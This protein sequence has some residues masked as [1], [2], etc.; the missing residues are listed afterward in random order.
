MK[1]IFLLLIICLHIFQR[2]QAAVSTA[3][4]TEKGSAISGAILTVEDDKY[5]YMLMHAGTWPQEFSNKSVTDF[6]T[7]KYT[8]ENKKVYS[9]PWT[10]TVPFTL[11]SWNQA[12]AALPDVTGSLT[13]GYDPR[14]KAAYKDIDVFSIPN[15]YKTKLIVGAVTPTAPLTAI[16]TDVIIESSIQTE[17]YY[18]LNQNSTVVIES[19]KDAY[20]NTLELKWPFLTGAEEYDVEWVFVSD[21]RLAKQPVTDL[22]LEF[23]NAT[24]IS[25]SKNAYKINLV[26]DDGYIYY[27]VR[28]VGRKGANFTM[29]QEGKWSTPGN[30]H[31]T[32]Y[33]H[34]RNWSYSA[35]YAEDGKA[36]EVVSFF[37]GSGRNRQAVTKLN[38]ENTVLAT[39]IMYDFEGR[40]GIQTLPAPI[41]DFKDANGIA[42]DHRVSRL[43]FYKQYSLSNTT[44]VEFSS[45]DFDNDNFFSSNNCKPTSNAGM[46]TAQGA[47]NYYSASNPEKDKGFNAVIP[48]AK[49]YP[50][51]QTVYDKE[52][53]VKMQSG[54]GDAHKIGAGH[55]T[56]FFNATV[57][58]PQ[59]DRLFGND[60]GYAS[61]YSQKAVMDANG[62][63]S[64]SYLDLSGK[65]IASFLTGAN[66][67]NL[68]DLSGVG[69]G[70][71]TDNFNSLNEL[72]S[73]EEALI[74]DAKYFV[75]SLGAYQFN[76]HISKEQYDFLCTDGGTC[77]YDLLI[78][79]YDECDQPVLD[80]NNTVLHHKFVINGETDIPFTVTF[81]RIGIYKIR[82]KLS[83]NE[84]A[85]KQALQLF[86]SNLK[87]P[88]NTCVTSLETL[89]SQ[90]NN[91]IDVS[92]CNVSAC[93]QSCKDAATLLYGS[94][95]TPEWYYEVER[96]K[97]KC[98][99]GPKT[100]CD[101]L[102][103]QL[104]RDMSPGG[105]YFE[106][107]HTEDPQYWFQWLEGN[108]WANG[109][110]A[111]WNAANFLD[112]EQHVITT[113]QE[114][115]DNWQEDYALKPF[116][117]PVAGR[118]SLVEFHP[119]YCH[120]QWCVGVKPST[121]FDMTLAATN[122]YTQATSTSA[123]LPYLDLNQA[124]F[125][126]RNMVDTDPYFNLVGLGMD[127]KSTMIGYLF[128]MDGA[129]PQESMWKEALKITNCTACT[130]P[131]SDEQWETF[132]ALYLAKKA[133]LVY[134]H[135]AAAG[136][137]IICDSSN[138]PDNIADGCGGSTTT[139][140]TS[141]VHYEI[142]VP[143][144]NLEALDPAVFA[145]YID[146]AYVPDCTP[147]DPCISE[148]HCL[149]EQFLNYE[150]L[151][152]YISPITNEPYVPRDVNGHQIIS[153]EAF[154]A[155]ALNKEYNFKPISPQNPG[156]LTPEYILE[157]MDSCRA[158]NNVNPYPAEITGFVPLGISND[159][160]KIFRCDQIPPECKEPS[161]VITNFY[162]NEEYNKQVK[163]SLE[164]F[165]ANYKAACLHTGLEDFTVVH[166]EQAG[167]YTLYYYDRAGN[168]EKTVP[169]AGVKPLLSEDTKHVGEYRNGVTGIDPVYPPH[170]LVTTYN[171]NTFNE[172]TAQTTPD[173]GTSHFWYN[174]VG[175]LR[176]SM[177]AKQAAQAVPN[178]T[179]GPYSYT[180]YDAQGR[181][182]EVGESKQNPP[183]IDLGQG[184]FFYFEWAVN[185][186][187]FPINQRKQVTQTTYDAPYSQLIS[188]LFPDHK[189]KNLRSRVASVFYDEDAEDN[190]APAYNHATHYSYDPHGNVNVLL[191]DNPELKDIDQNIKKIEYSYDLVSGNVNQVSYQRDAADQFHHR[192][193]YDDDNR[194]TAAFTSKDGLI[195]TN[196]AKYYYY[197]HGPLARM[198]LGDKKVQGLDYAYTIQGWLKSVNGSAIDAVQDI[199][200]DG[201]AGNKY[202]PS[203]PDLHKNVA[204]DAFAYS[205]NYF[206]NDYTGI[207]PDANHLFL[208]DIN[209]AAINKDADDLFNGNIKMKTVGLMDI[210]EV[211]GA[212]TLLPVAI[213]NYRYDQLNRI[214]KA[215]YQFSADNQFSNLQVTGEYNST[216]EYDRNGNIKKLTRNGS[217]SKGI[218]MDV[219]NYHYDF[220]HGNPLFMK[221]NRLLHVNDDVAANTNYDD[222]E[223]QG[224]FSSGEPNTWNY[225]YDEIGNLT[226]D[227]QEGI[228]SIEWTVYGKIKGIHRI[229]GFKKKPGAN[230]PESADLEYAYDASGNRIRKTV[231]RRESS[232]LLSEDNWVSTY[233][234]RDAQGNVMATYERSYTKQASNQ[235]TD[236]FKLKDN[237]LYGSSRLGI[238]R[239]LAL[240]LSWTF[241]S[242]V[243]NGKFTGRAYIVPQDPQ[244]CMDAV[245]PKHFSRSSGFKQ[246]ELNDHLGNVASVVSDNVMAVDEGTDGIADYFEA[247]L[248]SVTDYYPFGSE[249]LDRTSGG[250]YRYGFNGKE[251]DNDVKGEGNQQDYGMRIYDPRLGKFLS[252]DPLT[253]GYSMLTPYQFASN[254]PMD[255]I[256][257]DGL[258]YTHYV[259]G[260]Q[261][262]DAEMTPEHATVVIERTQV[263]VYQGMG[264]LGEL[265]GYGS[266]KL[267]FGLKHHPKIIDKAPVLF[268]NNMH[269]QFKSFSDLNKAV[270][271]INW[272]SYLKG[273][274][275]GSSAFAYENSMECKSEKIRKFYESYNNVAFGLLSI[276]GHAEG[277]LGR[278]NPAALESSVITKE[279]SVITEIEMQ[280]NY[281]YGSIKTANQD[282]FVSATLVDD[283]TNLLFSDT[284]I[285]PMELMNGESVLSMEELYT[286]YKNTSNGALYEAMKEFRKIAKERGFK[287]FSFS[288]KRVTGVNT[289][290]VQKSKKYN[291]E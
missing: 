199:G 94:K 230:E 158:S 82:K 246:Y 188:D 194:I 100:D 175:Q 114:L 205:L 26:Y 25:T 181:I 97:L 96:C 134:E 55:E 102:L 231:K 216:Y 13:V 259:V 112:K 60:V 33:G 36:K 285:I 239:N 129:G 209:N 236:E 51:T 64:V 261:F 235:F 127:E 195:W 52:G 275:S 183:E 249:I 169:P 234:V 151:W 147:S 80:A 258:E 273:E 217:A 201:M 240:S 160:K 172:L 91:S 255:G 6:I 128:D 142:R 238:Y 243:V 197:L 29:R 34:K 107:L 54:P 139:N 161:V 130:A 69:A 203:Q 213:T 46:E 156:I 2:S 178:Q 77:V 226:G 19:K 21:Q 225:K 277:M 66:T 256:D 117:S 8:G 290:K 1:R 200:K 132:R 72:S 220:D 16:P 286:K 185:D 211:T 263:Q 268:F 176:F 18:K 179:P 59:L 155:D 228:E 170:Q 212:A 244:P 24:R 136:C 270:L 4:A 61:H 224:D 167:Q 267:M 215:D 22:N 250:S 14:S 9:Q 141:V 56:Q 85:F 174:D 168:L 140:N 47:S 103:K 62:Q 106:N 109:N 223:D 125:I 83:I 126:G 17:R 190:N 186:A 206:K 44:H 45:K 159:L 245:C 260:L 113:W 154:I 74:V 98:A 221:S 202:M 89:T 105:Q 39:E 278:P 12:G 210:D 192:Y 227:K 187:S 177:N 38:T 95:P 150:Q 115:K 219:L 272:D 15:A 90:F 157:C 84:E 262:R 254:R 86:K 70:E 145:N 35:T 271:S 48:D 31:Y 280:Q 30:I 81:P 135:R 101:V 233:Y 93:E 118:N 284:N 20:T 198:E 57:L 123:G 71:V 73:T 137:L 207:F 152:N 251:N 276:L 28:G 182:K 252:V 43:D 218:P 184:T 120:Y 108:A 242:T 133:R 41:N 23:D 87:L 149:C 32:D 75:S 76:Y 11:K 122:T 92:D 291:V 266:M 124:P 257:I 153:L 68:D 189:Q 193:T 3:L 237:T 279:A 99:G 269:F 7:L 42:T 165:V 166:A 131:F 264:A 282:I 58:Q 10:L 119:E 283:G 208:G 104:A 116:N 144:P 143:Y 196:D 162:A 78:T 110:T 50:F 37:D 67:T 247:E 88:G 248:I 148:R 229:P 121:D 27:R 63:L 5:D 79:I 288:G 287:T 274:G 49:L 180:K 222:I 232:A 40:A 164:E 191:Q 289:G 265:Y 163:E 53:K 138:P 65:V 111:A 173:A 241:T 171:Y 146:T 214:T 253:R 281:L 204:R